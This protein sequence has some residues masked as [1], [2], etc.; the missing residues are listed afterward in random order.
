MFSDYHQCQSTGECI[1]PEWICDGKFHCNDHS[2]EE[3]DPFFDTCDKWDSFGES[4]PKLCAFPYFECEDFRNSNPICAQRCD[5]IVEC[6][7]NIDEVGKSFGCEDNIDFRG[8]LTARDELQTFKFPESNASY[9]NDMRVAWLISSNYSEIFVNATLHGIEN[10]KGEGG[11]ACS[12]VLQVTAGD[13]LHHLPN[14]SNYPSYRT[15]HH[16]HIHTILNETTGKYA[17]Y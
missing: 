11:R 5:K 17:P 6:R 1:P 4:V 12:D 9:E 16:I 13:C 8:V 7:D 15:S 10:C 3:K 2:D 14:V